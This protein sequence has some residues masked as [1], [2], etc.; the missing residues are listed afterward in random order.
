MSIQLDK[1]CMILGYNT[2]ILIESLNFYYQ[3]FHNCTY[4]KCIKTDFN[5]MLNNVV[6]VLID[7]RF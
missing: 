6:N 5:R 7:F 3:V 2:L 1:G 4:I